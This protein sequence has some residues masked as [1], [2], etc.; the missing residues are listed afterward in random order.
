MKKL[1]LI[2]TLALFT[3]TAFAQRGAVYTATYDTIIGNETIYT[4]LIPLSGAYETVT[5]QALL[6]QVG[7][8]SDGQLILQASVDGTSYINLAPVTGRFD[9]FPNNDTLTITN[10][11][12]QTV[13]ITD[14]PFNYYRWKGIGTAG[15]STLI[16]TKYTFK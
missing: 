3:A 9:Y 16:T 15:D 10:G 8:I 5:I 6:T 12:I 14:N 4:G 13:T 11:A 2:L 7:G 1:I